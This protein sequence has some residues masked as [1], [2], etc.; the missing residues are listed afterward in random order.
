MV[1]AFYVEDNAFLYPWP[2]LRLT[3]PAQPLGLTNIPYLSPL[4]STFGGKSRQTW[5]GNP[6]HSG[7]EDPVKL[8]LPVPLTL[9]VRNH[10]LMQE[11]IATFSAA[12]LGRFAKPVGQLHPVSV[13]T[14]ARAIRYVV[15]ECVP[16]CGV[17]QRIRRAGF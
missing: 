17:Q 1:H 5:Y 2:S 10:R 14:A 7:A 3:G 13:F 9:F 15:A 8:R 4:N 16:P 11:P 12:P 6:Q